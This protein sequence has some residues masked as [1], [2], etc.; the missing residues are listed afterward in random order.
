MNVIDNNHLNNIC[1]QNVK[2]IQKS[3]VQVRALNPIQEPVKLYKMSYSFKW[4]IFR[5]LRYEMLLFSTAFY[6]LLLTIV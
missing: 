2:V 3:K 1:D 5:H 6:V 4:T